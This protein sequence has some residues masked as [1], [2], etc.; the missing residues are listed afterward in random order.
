M[1]WTPGCGKLV[2]CFQ[3]SHLCLICVTSAA[4]A[5]WRPLFAAFT[6]QI[7]GFD[8][9]CWR[10]RADEMLVPDST[11]SL[12]WLMSGGF[13]G[14]W[15]VRV[16]RRHELLLHKLLSCPTNKFAM[17]SVWTLLHAQVHTHC[18]TYTNA[19]SLTHKHTQTL[20]FIWIP[21]GSKLIIR[22]LTSIVLEYM[23]VRAGQTP[24]V[25]E[26]GSIKCTLN[27]FGWRVIALITVFS[28]WEARLTLKYCLLSRLWKLPLCSLCFLVWGVSWLFGFSAD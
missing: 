24:V 9:I 27:V 2:S 28:W 25:F 20:S 19:L 1:I 7:W 5:T 14:W 15:S 10:R 6:T 26:H 8:I 3:E 23:T 11:W 17:L 4:R 22:T 21:A 18:H 12:P 16:I 13:Q